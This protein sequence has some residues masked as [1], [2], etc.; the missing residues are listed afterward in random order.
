MK[1][2]L[3]LLTILLAVAAVGSYF[4]FAGK[5]YQIILTE[6][7]ITEKLAQ[8]LPLTRSYFLII[9]ITLDN[10]RI[11]LVDGSNRIK[12]GLDV[13]MNI[14]IKNQEQPLG[15][16][17][18]VSGGIRYQPESAEFFLTDAIIEKV[19]VQGLAEKYSN[20]ANKALS[21]AMTQFF[22]NNAIYTLKATDTKKAAAKLLLKNVEIRN[23]ELLISLGV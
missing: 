6:A 12:A 15:G 21:K 1:K 23:Q 11:N 2:S 19:K 10:P 22:N 18:D 5:Q 4:Y 17:I 16:S 20:K 8:K 13:Q 9:H 7:Q 3:I 14:R